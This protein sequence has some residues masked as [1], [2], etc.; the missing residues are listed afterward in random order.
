MGVIDWIE[1]CLG[2]NGTEGSGHDATLAIQETYT[3]NGEMDHPTGE[4]WVGHTDTGSDAYG[5]L[6]NEIGPGNFPK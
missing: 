2:C 1:N 6:P 5:N 4:S 3:T